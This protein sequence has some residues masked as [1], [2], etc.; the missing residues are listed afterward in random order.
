[1][2]TKADSWLITADE[3][4]RMD[5]GPDRRAEL[6][7]GVVRMMG[8]G[9][10]LHSRVQTRLLVALSKALTGSGCEA[11]GPDMGVRIDGDTVRYPDVSIYCGRDNDPAFDK[12]TVGT[13]PKVVIEVLSESTSRIDQRE[14]LPQYQSVSSIQSIMYV[15]PEGELIRSVHRTGTL[16]WQDSGLIQTLSLDVPSLD[17]SIPVS[18]IFARA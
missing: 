11:H 13:D 15:D 4:L 1:M 18:E 7:E 2:A 17:V 6:V 10:R 3:F 16:S 14:K 9:T 12:E 5:F 8:G